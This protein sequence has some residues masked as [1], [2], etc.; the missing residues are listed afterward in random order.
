MRHGTCI[1]VEKTVWLLVI[2]ILG[3]WLFTSSGWAADKKEMIEFT[4]GL[5]EAEVPSDHLTSPYM[6]NLLMVEARDDML[7]VPNENTIIYLKGSYEIKKY[8]FKDLIP[9]VEIDN[10]YRVSLKENVQKNLPIDLAGLGPFYLA[11]KKDKYYLLTPKNFAKIFGGIRSEEEALNYLAS[12]ENLFVSPVVYV[13]TPETERS[14][15]KIERKPPRLSQAVKTAEGF[16]VVMVI[17]A[18]IRVDGFFEKKVSL[19]PEGVVTPSEEKPRMIL[20]FGEG[21]TY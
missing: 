14:L 5:L 8:K 21:I 6:L 3:G 10:F 18:V 9:R 19:T 20:K 2:V 1:S 17:Y 11:E 16:D 12:Y 7:D 13:A 4:E 15:K